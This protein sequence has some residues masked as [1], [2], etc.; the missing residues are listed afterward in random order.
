MKNIM[1]NH[2]YKTLKNLPTYWEVNA[3]YETLL[4]VAKI[5]NQ[6]HNFKWPSDV[7][8]FFDNPK[9]YVDEVNAIIKEYEEVENELSSVPT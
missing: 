9:K 8:K 4:D 7:F 5:L 1:Y 6:F 3:D 2:D